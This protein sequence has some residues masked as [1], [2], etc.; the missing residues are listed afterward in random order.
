MCVYARPLIAKTH[1]FYHRPIVERLSIYIFR[2]WCLSSLIKT[3]VDDIS[4]MD[5]CVFGYTSLCSYEYPMFYMTSELVYANGFIPR[6]CTF[7]ILIWFDNFI[8]LSLPLSISFYFHI[9]YVPI[10]FPNTLKFHINWWFS[11]FHSL[12]SL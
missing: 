7:S 8:F 2:N 11:Q 9:V 12:I 10:N 1:N 5:L 3:D 6:R 4:F